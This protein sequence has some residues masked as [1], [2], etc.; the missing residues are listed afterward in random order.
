MRELAADEY[1]RVWRAFDNRY[2]FRPGLRGP[3]PGILEPKDS[4]CFALRDGDLD[5]A[6]DD[7]GKLLREAFIATVGPDAELYYLDWQHV[8]YRGRAGDDWKGRPN[9]IGDGDYA[10]L[11]TLDLA[12][13]SFGHPWEWSLCLFGR[14]FVSEV[15]R[16][17]PRI[18][19]RVLRNEGGYDFTPSR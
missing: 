4:I 2:Q 8:C 18:F 15:L 12:S 6:I 1:D 11:L 14:A 9:G 16:R 17:G 7:Y 19:E 13:G 3:F 5:A 10:I